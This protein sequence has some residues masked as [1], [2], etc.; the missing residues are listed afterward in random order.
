MSCYRVG[1]T[2]GPIYKVFQQVTAPVSSW[3]ASYIFSYT[4]KQLATHVMQTYGKGDGDL[5]IL[6]YLGFDETGRSIAKESSNLAGIGRY[7]DRAFFQITT[8]LTVDELKA[9]IAHCIHETKEDILQALPD[10]PGRDEF[11][12]NELYIEF[13]IQPSA[14][15]GEPTVKRLNRLLDVAEENA[16]TQLEFAH[17]YINEIFNTHRNEPFQERFMDVEQRHNPLALSKDENRGYA[18]I[19]SIARRINHRDRKASRYY[20]VVSFDGDSVSISIR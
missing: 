10:R 11:V 7:P 17:D 3:A 2:I 20:A 1:F 13:V 18:D 5:L 19:G 8:D 4:M 14:V 15:R 12:E 16:G 6:P 9:G